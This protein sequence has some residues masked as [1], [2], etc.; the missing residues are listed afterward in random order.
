MLD[1]LLITAV[2]SGIDKDKDSI[3]RSGK[4]G[5]KEN[6]N[7]ERYIT[8][9]YGFPIFHKCFLVIQ[10]VVHRQYISVLHIEPMEYV[11]Y[12]FPFLFVGSNEE[13]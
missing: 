5:R 1:M 3:L 11:Q 9:Q 4:E 7:K 10:M 2:G 13:G 12:L 8:S 6:N